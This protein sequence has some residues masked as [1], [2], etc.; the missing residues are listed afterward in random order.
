MGNVLYVNS[1]EGTD[2]ILKNHSADNGIH[3]FSKISHNTFLLG[4]FKIFHIQPTRYLAVK[5]I[6]PCNLNS[7]VK[8]K[9]FSLKFYINISGVILDLTLLV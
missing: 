6:V 2:K 1:C 9:S 3:K 4:P 8:S 7:C 5:I